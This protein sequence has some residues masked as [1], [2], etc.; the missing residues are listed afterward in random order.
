MK[1]SISRIAV[2]LLVLGGA[3]ALAAVFSHPATA[4][5][6][7]PARVV[8]APA[9]VPAPVPTGVSAIGTFASVNQASLAFQV[10]GRVQAIK[11]NEGDQVKAGDVLATLDTSILASQVVQA[12]AAL[13]IA[14]AKLDQLKNPPAADV[15][16]A[17]ANA[18][19]ADAALAQLKTPS[20][21]DLIMAKSDFDKAQAELNTA[22]AAFDRIGGNTN[23]FIAMTPQSQALQQAYDDFKKAQ[24]A[25]NAKISP[26]DSQLKQAL[27]TVAQAHDQLA[28]LVSPDPD[29]LKSAQAGVDQAQAALDVTKQNV[30][31]AQ[32]VAPFDGTVVWIGPHLGESMAP[33]V[34]EMTVADLS[35]MQIKVGVDENALA[36]IKLGQPA[37][38]TADALPGKTLTGKVSEIG[39]L[40]A[41]TAGIVSV[42]VTID[43]AP[44]SAPIAPGLSATVSI[45]VPK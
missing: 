38:I 33:G 34:P 37:A 44:S 41:N 2:G 32:I 28:R 1:L 16:A 18:T 23:P 15:A 31:N 45:N 24:A 26:T 11:V 10:A 17:Q 8:Q 36:Q 30:V 9:P 25:Y 43:V 21:N 42:P 22:Q 40:A 7:R 6:N 27:A 3:I 13:D 4:A 5:T 29:D 39:M 35:R 14:Q 12:Q 19:S 20:Q